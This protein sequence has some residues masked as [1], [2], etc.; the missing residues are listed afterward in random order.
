MKPLSKAAQT[1]LW[2]SLAVGAGICLLKK[3]G[4]KL[5]F[6]SCEAGKKKEEGCGCGTEGGCSCGC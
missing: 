3:Q 2:S 6:C 5:P 1:F 4:V